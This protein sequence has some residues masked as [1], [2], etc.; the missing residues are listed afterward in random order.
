MLTDMY[1]YCENS[2]SGIPPSFVKSYIYSLLFG[3][4]F[5]F[6]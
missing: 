4:G 1:T 5:D 6:V 2:I 3:N